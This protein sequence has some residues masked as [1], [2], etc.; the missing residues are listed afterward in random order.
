MTDKTSLKHKAEFFAVKGLVGALGCLPLPV[1]SAVGYGLGWV[2]MSV[3]SSL[4]KKAMRNLA[5]AFPD[6]DEKEK[7]RI[8]K[9]SGIHMMQTFIEACRIYKMPEKR[10]T[11]RFNVFGEE[12]VKDCEGAILLTGHYG[13]WEALLRVMAVKGFESVVVYRPANNALVDEIITEMRAKT[14]IGAAPKGK[15]GARTLIKA[16]KENKYI[17]I[18]NDQKMREGAELTLF[19]HKAHT[20]TGFADMAIKYNK[21]MVPF[22]CRRVGLG[23]YEIDILPQLE[24]PEGSYEEKVLKLTQAYNDVL[25]AQVRAFPEQWMWQHSRFK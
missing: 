16:C 22:F 21:P 24:M 11:K 1:V 5:I 18:L 17:G 8:A 10:F 9:R 4:R 19:G 12:N 25:E 2:A 15:A 14:G 7:R 13:N 3:P 6:M 20:S 23:R